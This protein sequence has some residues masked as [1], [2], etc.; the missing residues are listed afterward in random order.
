MLLFEKLSQD[1]E[2]FVKVGGKT[3]FDRFEVKKLLEKAGLADDAY[4]GA[5]RDEIE[6]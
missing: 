5:G 4:G 6:R 3:K 2:E 1:D